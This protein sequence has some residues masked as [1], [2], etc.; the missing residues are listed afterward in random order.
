[1]TIVIPPGYA[2][3][4][5]QL[6][7]SLMPRMAYIT[8]GCDFR[9]A[10]GDF[11]GAV[12]DVR[13]AWAGSMHLQM[14]NSVMIGPVTARVGT[15]SGEPIVYTDSIAPAMG[16]VTG[17]VLPPAVALLV[18][19]R[20]SRGGRRGRGRLFIPWCLQGANVDEAGVI[21]G[22]RMTSLSTAL[23]AW[24]TALVT[25]SVPMVLLHGTGQSTLG[26]PDVVTALFPDNRVASQRRRQGR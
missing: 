14:D 1:M 15:D 6:S 9:D 22:A 26:G 24:R 2:Q 10:G 3:C 16:A 23:A 5:I 18:H 4:N 19:K 7:H 25:A 21:S 11:Q 8:W 12:D 13:T 20:T 17:S